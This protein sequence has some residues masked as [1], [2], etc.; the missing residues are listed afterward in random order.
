[1]FTS[2]ASFSLNGYWKDDKPKMFITKQLDYDR[3]QQG[4]LKKFFKSI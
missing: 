2:K 1:M 3:L 4:N